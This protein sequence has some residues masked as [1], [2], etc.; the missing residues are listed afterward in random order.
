[1]ASSTTMPMASTRPNSERL[2][3][4]KPSAASMAK[5]PISDTGMATIGMIDARQVCRNRM[6]TT[7]TRITASSMVWITASTDCEM[8]TVGL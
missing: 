5:V 7:T 6:I 2:F 4:E 8:N 1:M 3:S